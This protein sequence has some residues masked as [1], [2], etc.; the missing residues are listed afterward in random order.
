MSRT[1]IS[2]EDNK[3][4]FK[5]IYK[6]KTIQDTIDDLE[7]IAADLKKV[8]TI[9]PKAN[10]SPSNNHD[11]GRIYYYTDRIYELANEFVIREYDDDDGS[12]AE[13]CY[14]ISDKVKVWGPSIDIG[15]YSKINSYHLKG[16]EKIL[17]K[18]KYN[19]E[20]KT[21]LYTKVASIANSRDKNK[22]RELKEKIESAEAELKRLSK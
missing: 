17:L 3:D 18:S 8:Q 5:V 15:S 2:I 4:V 13:V 9:F 14:K 16:F 6:G 10:F 21:N 22:A 11:G 1:M 19:Q 7:N 20:L 12:W